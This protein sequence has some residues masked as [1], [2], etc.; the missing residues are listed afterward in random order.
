MGTTNGYQTEAGWPQSPGPDREANLRR[1]KSRVVVSFIDQLSEE[2][3]QYAGCCSASR[4]ERL[5]AVRAKRDSGQ[6]RVRYRGVCKAGPLD[7]RWCSANS[8]QPGGSQ[9]R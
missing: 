6:G 4:S 8:A 1:S 3:G 7:L 2:I 5:P 9:R